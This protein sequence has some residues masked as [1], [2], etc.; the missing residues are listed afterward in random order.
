MA[1]FGAQDGKEDG[2][3]VDDIQERTN[4]TRLGSLGSSFKHL[5]CQIKNSKF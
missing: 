5:Y 2:E 4:S 1:R 3:G